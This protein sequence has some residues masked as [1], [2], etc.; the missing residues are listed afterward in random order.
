[1]DRFLAAAAS[2]AHALRASYRLPWLSIHFRGLGTFALAG[3]RQA[4]CDPLQLDIGFLRTPHVS[5]A[6]DERSLFLPR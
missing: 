3:A 6:L 4:E 2:E 5:V 1:M